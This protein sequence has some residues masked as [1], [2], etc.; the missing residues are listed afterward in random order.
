MA[1]ACVLSFASGAAVAQIVTPDA[2]PLAPKQASKPQKFQ[3]FGPQQ[4]QQLAQTP[5]FAPPASAA[6]DTGYDSTNSRRAKARKQAATQKPGA[7]ARAQA[8]ALTTGQPAPLTL[9]PYQKPFPTEAKSAMAAAAGQPPVEIGPIRKPLKKRRRDDAD[10]PYAPL[11]VHAG[12]FLLYPAIELSGGYSTN[13]GQSSNPAGASLYSAA[14]ELRA[15]SNWSRHELKAD[16]RGSYTGYSPDTTPTL[17]RPYAN[18]KIDGRVDVTRS[19]RIDL[20]GRVLVSTDNPG[21]PNLQAGLSKLPI[22]TTAGGSV[23]LGQKFNR[24]DLSLKGDAE[25]TAY[26][27]SKLTDGTTASNEDRNYDQYGVTLR[28]GYELTP[29]VTP[30]VEGTVDTRRHD[31]ATDFSGYQRNSKGWTALVGSTFELSRLLTGE[32]GIG[33]TERKYDDTRL[34]K[35]SGFVGNASLIWTASSLTTVQFNAKSA[36]QESA[37]AGVSGVLSRDFGLQVD[38]AFR[39]WLIGSVKA[40]Y[41]ND[42]YK[43]SSRD[44]NRY[45]VALGLTYKLSRWAQ[46]KGEF[47]QDWLRSNF[48]G[49]DYTAS[50]FLVGVRLQQ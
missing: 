31:L 17:S 30:Y 21:S 4:Q 8:Q 1:L 40:G 46:I 15:Q 6:G 41:G 47:R 22:F 50:T 7:A 3:K 2:D 39:R 19:T 29:G 12:G 43:G 18:G 33:Y 37:V 27:N 38:H 14:P 45:M 49:N 44:D 48:S 10:D 23:G 32:T 26:Q 36:V 9:S 34:D 42:D 16:L 35:L 5:S 11:G 24:L 13:P 25:R 20:G 28:G